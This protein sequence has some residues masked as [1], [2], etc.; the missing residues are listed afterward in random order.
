MFSNMSNG[1]KRLLTLSIVGCGLNNES[2]SEIGKSFKGTN[3]TLS[4]NDL[5]FQSAS[6][7]K[8]IFGIERNLKLLDLSSNK[9][10]GDK[11]VDILFSSLAQISETQDKDSILT[12][13]LSNCGLT[14]ESCDIIGDSLS[15]NCDLG[16]LILNGNDLG[17]GVSE[18]AKQLKNNR[19][20]KFLSLEKCGVDDQALKEFSFTISQC[21][22][23]K[24]DLTGN[25]FTDKGVNYLSDGLLES[26]L[27]LR[28]L[29]LSENELGMG[30]VKSLSLVLRLSGLK[31]VGLSFGH[32]QSSD[33]EKE[34]VILM[35]E[36]FH[37]QC[38]LDLGLVTQHIVSLA[39][40]QYATYSKK[41]KEKQKLETKQGKQQEATSMIA[42]QL[43]KNSVS[44]WLLSRG[45]GK[46]GKEVINGKANSNNDLKNSK[47]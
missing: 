27:N 13:D 34:L 24:L 9:R 11:G 45:V 30:S 19:Q 37:S 41:E 47:T 39:K 28:D 16:S 8:Q 33:L 46:E 7:L 43:P 42:A 31:H 3:L 10:F 20:L 18:L 44:Q 36:S 17:E 5:L 4:N 26:D 40:A 29:N 25:I 2:I 23:E 1:F 6:S 21:N 14:S 22:L 15:L 12:I 32:E 38:K 35:C